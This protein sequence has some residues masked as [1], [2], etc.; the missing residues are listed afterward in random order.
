M[1]SN[2]L[3]TFVISLLFLGL[4]FCGCGFW[5]SQSPKVTQLVEQ[6]SG[7]YDERRSASDALVQLG[8]GAVPAL[9]EATRAEASLVRWEAVNA[10]GYI[11]SPKAIP[12]VLE[13][14]LIDTDVHAR[15]RSIWA[16]GCI[17]DGSAKS[18][19]PKHLTDNN[20]QRR[21]NAAIALSVISDKANSKE[22]IPILHQ[23]LKS[24]DSW[25][26]WEAANAL[27]RTYNEQTVDLL[28]SAYEDSNTSTRQ[29]IVLSLGRIGTPKVIPTLIKA[30]D[31][32]EREVRW[33]A[34]M[35]LGWVGDKSAVVALQSH[36]ESETDELVREHIEESLKKI[37][38][39]QPAD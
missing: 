30:L 28:V 8:E 12:A 22:A 33:R 3:S 20:P 36:L 7:E 34:A 35:A 5:L 2:F 23:G 24:S 13:R 21:W 15:W 10:L 16:L 39:S 37:D 1:Y 29:E 9:I 25:T 4:F 18:R 6:L 31:D 11:G 19:L 26:R 32:E 27:G 17:D 38:Y 14:V